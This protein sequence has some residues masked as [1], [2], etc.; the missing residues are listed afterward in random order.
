MGREALPHLLELVR[1]KDG[2][3][4]SKAAYLAGIIDA[5]LSV[6]VLV[7]AAESSIPEV[8]IAS[9]AAVRHL[10]RA[11]SAEVIQRLEKLPDPG[12][13]KLLRRRR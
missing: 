2:M 3:L 9:A 10:R 13:H 4:A 7:A 12:V 1:G 8:R 11:P 5:D 6:D